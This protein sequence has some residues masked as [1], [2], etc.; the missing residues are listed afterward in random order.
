MTDRELS[1]DAVRLAG[2][3]AAPE[4]PADVSAP[5]LVRVTVDGTEVLVEPGATL[6]E[7]ARSAGAAVPTL[8]QDDRLA[9]YG[10]CRV[11]LV[12]VDGA[13]G[14]VASCVMPCAPGMVVSTRDPATVR[15]AT[16]VLELMVSQLPERAL[17]VPAERSELVRVCEQLGVDATSFGTS[18][19]TGPGGFDFSH[20]YVKLDR[21]L[22]IACGRCVRM[23]D[24]VQGTFALT[25]ANR[26]DATVVAPGS[27]GP[28]AGSD[29]VACGGDGVKLP[30][31]GDAF[32]TPRFRGSGRNA[33]RARRPV[34]RAFPRAENARNR[35]C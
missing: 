24:E 5:K 4:V 1:P 33:L 28:W 34:P 29:C 26:G 18:Y 30:Q 31:P 12:H 9:P 13:G 6:L 14:P 21:D 11:C 20:P 25:L 3:G 35:R 22:C 15:A 16:S 19:G 8:C 17:D 32:P 10:S 23:C 7:A 27:G 2:V